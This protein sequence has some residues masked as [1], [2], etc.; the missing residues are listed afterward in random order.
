MK[1]VYTLVRFDKTPLIEMG[2]KAQGILALGW[3]YEERLP[4]RWTVK[5]SKAVGPDAASATADDEIKAL[6]GDYWVDP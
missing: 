1:T 4:D 5:F 2:Q 6:M 3:E